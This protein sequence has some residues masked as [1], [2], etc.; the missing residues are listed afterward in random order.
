VNIDKIPFSFD[1]LDSESNS[2]M[3]QNIFSF[4]F[5][6]TKIEQPLQKII[7]N[8]SNIYQKN[9]TTPLNKQDAYGKNYCF[10]N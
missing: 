2:L 1:I 10:D 6:H 8:P 9:Y 5:I 4:S 3:N 7:C